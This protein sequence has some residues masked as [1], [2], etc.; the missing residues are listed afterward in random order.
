M[1][2]MDC[3]NGFNTMY[4]YIIF[5]SV[6]GFLTSSCNL[7][8]NAPDNE[9]GNGSDPDT[10][11]KFQN[12]S[13]SNLPSN[14]S[15]ATSDAT[16]ADIDNDGDLDLIQAIQFEPNRL[17]INNGS[18]NFS[19]QQLASLN[20]DSRDVIAGHFDSDSNIDQSDYIDI[21]IANNSTQTSEYYLNDDDGTFSELNNRISI[22]GSFT[23][24]ATE[25]TDG[26]GATDILI[27]SN[28][29]NRLLQNNGNGFFN[30]QTTRLPQLS[31]AT[32][33][34]AFGDLTSNNLPDIAV[35]NG[36]TNKILINNGAGF[37][38]D[39]SNR[40]SF[41][42]EIEES[43]DIEL[44]DVDRDGDLDIYLGN[45]NFQEGANP[46]DRLLIND[47]EGFFSDQTTD[48]LPVL[49][50][51]TFDAELADLDNDGNPDLIVGNYNGGIRVLTNNGSGF[52]TDQT[53]RWIPEDFTPPV[54]DLEIADFNGD[55]LPDMY[56]SV[57]EGSDQL[58]I[59]QEQ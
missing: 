41:T 10:T 30:N 34:V 14:L 9:N 43:R 11:S 47:G 35:A 2:F 15:G 20:F 1:L 44:A 5:L 33:D 52:Y 28:G 26:D 55:G 13:S 7:N 17:L 21:F 36:G 27:G 59:Q 40:Y 48:R 51:N 8:L 29:Q 58:L 3:K 45:S 6:L 42:N 12:V 53:D 18:G 56:I 46:Q 50:A 22:T 24:A 39:Q 38:T 57:R 31:N 16:A 23:S 32:H 49:T 4:R 37:Y 25:D 19:I 54:M